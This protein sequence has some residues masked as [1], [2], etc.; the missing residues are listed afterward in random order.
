[1]KTIIQDL[2]KQNLIDEDTSVTLFES[3][4]KHKELIT[5][6][7]KKNTGKK[8][9]KKYSPTVRQFALSLHF[10]SAKAYDYMAALYAALCIMHYAAIRQHLEYDGNKYYGRVDMGIGINNDSLEVAKECLVFLVVSVN[11]SWKLPIAY[12]LAR[13]LNSSQ[14]SELIHHA[15]HVL[16]STGVKIIS[17]TF[18]GCSSNINTAQILGCT[19]NV[20]TLNTSFTSGCENNPNIVTL[21]DPAHM[22]KLVRNAFGEKKV[23][24]DFEGKEINVEYIKLLCCLQEKEGCHLAN[25]LRKQHIFYFKQKMKV[26][27]ATQLL[28]Q[29]VADALKFCKNSL[30][31]N[32]FCNADAT[33]QFIELFNIAFDILNSRSINC[34]GYNKALCK[35]NIESVILFTKKIKTYIKGLK[36]E[37]KPGIFVP[38]LHSSRKTGNCIPLEDIGILHYSSSDPVNVLNNN[39]PGF[40]YDAIIQEENL[41][42]INSFIL[43]HDYIGCHSNYSFSNFSKE[44]IIYISGFVVHKLTNVLKCDTNKDA[45]CATDKECFLNSLITLKNKK[46]DNG[47]LIYPS[48]DVID[49]CSK[50]EKTL[51]QFNYTDKAVNKLK[52]QSEVLGHFLFNSNVFKQ[53]KTHSSETRNPLTDHITL[54]IKSITSTYINL[55]INYNLKSH[56]ETP[57]IR[58]WYNKLTIFKGQ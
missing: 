16:E 34:I 3:F 13:S 43:D 15:L 18:D 49:I 21:L 32:E 46:G 1:M 55:K 27:L 47:G 24:L 45:L 9:S 4:G 35:E 58:M 17:L 22:V 36:V 14:K 19:Y 39:T 12:F 48:N 10:F 31:L 28:S 26:K 57:S 53:L 8:I 29:S 30:N 11:E 33:I 25:K 37:D 6:W 44:V 54:L 20:E 23:F 52:I 2:K 50:T 7:S 38:V 51:K 41:K 5:N 56:N 40:N 42:S